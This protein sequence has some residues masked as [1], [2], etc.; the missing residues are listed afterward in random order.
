[1][2][3]ADQP[4][5]SLDYLARAYREMHFQSNTLENIYGYFKRYPQEQDSYLTKQIIDI[6]VAPQHEAAI[7]AILDLLNQI[8]RS[9]TI[10]TVIFNWSRT[11]DKHLAKLITEKGWL[12]QN[13]IALRVLTMALTKHKPEK[14]T[15]DEL[16]WLVWISDGNAGK[17]SKKHRPLTKKYLRDCVDEQYLP[18]LE[19][20]WGNRFSPTIFWVLARRQFKFDLTVKAS[21]WRALFTP[22]MHAQLAAGDA[23]VAE[24]I[25]EAS[26]N[27]KEKIGELAWEVLAQMNNQ[28]AHDWLCR[29]TVLDLHS[30]LTRLANE[31]GWLPTKPD[32]RALFYFVSGRWDEYEKLDFDGRILR[33]TYRKGDKD[34]RRNLATKIRESGKP[35]YLA[36][37]TQKEVKN[38][39]E[40]LAN[41][42]AEIALKI[43]EDNQDWAALWKL[44]PQLPL[45]YA[46]A[47]VRRLATERWQPPN[48]ADQ[49]TLERLSALVQA[50]KISHEVAQISEV[51]P[52][53]ILFDKPIKLLPDQKIR[54]AL[55][56]F[57]YSPD[58]STI[59]LLA[60]SAGN[61]QLIA[62][63]SV[64]SLSVEKVLTCEAEDG[65]NKI[66]Y[67]KTGLLCVAGYSKNKPDNGGLYYWDAEK[68]EKFG[69]HQGKITVLEVVGENYLLSGGEDGFIKLWNMT[70]KNLVAE[71]EL[72]KAGKNDPPRSV[73]FA[74]DEQTLVVFHSSVA[75]YTLPDLKF[76]R[77]THLP[78]YTL[79]QKGVYSPDG[80]ELLVAQKDK[81]LQI[82]ELK[83]SRFG[84]R[85][86]VSTHYYVGWQGSDATPGILPLE[87][88]N[89]VILVRQ[90]EPFYVLDWW[91]KE[92]VAEIKIKPNYR[93]RSYFVKLA[94]LAPAG[95]QMALIDN[96]GYLA[97]LDLSSLILW[98]LFTQPLNRAGNL[99]LTAIANFLQNY[100]PEPDSGLANS[101]NFAKIVIEQ[102]ILRHA[103][104]IEGDKISTI[105]AEPLD[106]ELEE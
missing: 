29:Q 73:C 69:E 104:E 90:D 64:T 91:T 60:G 23:K 24:Y 48:P 96:D 99:H 94:K 87:P 16:N 106:I 98:Q 31:K 44:L 37:I 88:I 62:L 65:L 53:K 40:G 66:S 100:A 12:P 11:Q 28:A 34:T 57:A 41:K 102:I 101:L 76:I 20:M 71:V 6:L 3:Q 19:K 49:P 35:A 86:K 42:E 27:Y 32:E 14:L 61:S 21:V 68:F 4:L 55:K 52:L 105:Q 9:D 83:N 22:A 43:L 26:R 74:P 45:E 18:Y 25:L 8:T 54:E 13:N 39:P 47:A 78:D 93:A 92:K 81:E 56:D 75:L 70:T 63:F 5:T 80:R 97:I 77:Q 17:D 59:A 85:P 50:E 36:A 33:E 7:P 51:A 1:M 79:N 95:W 82:V 30:R 15:D 67:T 89:Y 38:Q 2:T 72:E 84:A 10:Q 46:I 103:I 58:N